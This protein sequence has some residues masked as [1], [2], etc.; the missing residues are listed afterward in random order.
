MS[1]AHPKLANEAAAYVLCTTKYGTCSMDQER[2]QVGWLQLLMQ[3]R[4]HYSY[5][6]Y[7]L[8]L[9]TPCDL[10]F[11]QSARPEPYAKWL[12]EASRQCTH[13]MPAVR[14]I[15]AVQLVGVHC[16]PI[17]LLP[18]LLLFHTYNAVSVIDRTFSAT[19][20]SCRRFVSASCKSA[21]TGVERTD[22]EAQPAQSRPWKTRSSRAPGAAAPT[23]CR[24]A[25]LSSCWTA[26]NRASAAMR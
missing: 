1:L 10:A 15:A 22:K 21:S 17:A 7:F 12:L 24:S 6:S 25:P 20:F 3:C 19:A 26:A 4:S 13:K 2:R 5:L 23:R 16:E 8:A 14:R 18:F 9:C 11:G